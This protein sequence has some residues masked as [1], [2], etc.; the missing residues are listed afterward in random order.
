MHEASNWV[1][2]VRQALHAALRILGV[3]FRIVRGRGALE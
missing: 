1:G 2:H 3:S